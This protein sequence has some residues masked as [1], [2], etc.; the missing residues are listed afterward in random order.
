MFRFTIDQHLAFRYYDA[1][2]EL[3][4]L[5]IDKGRLT[6]TLQ[7]FIADK[8]YVRC[9]FWYEGKEICSICKKIFSIFPNPDKRYCPCDFVPKPKLILTSIA[10]LSFLNKSFFSEHP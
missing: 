4:K 8:V 10:L 1:A 3:E 5:K 9:P 2:Q 6:V 7:K